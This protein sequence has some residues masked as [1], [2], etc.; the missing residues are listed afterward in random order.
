MLVLPLPTEPCSD[1]IK[2]LECRL[3]SSK[4]HQEHVDVK[5]VDAT[6]HLEDP[7]GPML[8]L[9]DKLSD[10][11]PDAKE[12]V[13]LVFEVSQASYP[14]RTCASARLTSFKAAFRLIC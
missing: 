12:T 14:T 1:L 11:L 7:N 9:E 6:L 10:V 4:T 3:P 13:V 2:A 8:Y 5:D